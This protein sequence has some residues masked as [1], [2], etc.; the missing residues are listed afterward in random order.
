MSIVVNAAR[1]QSANS[2][3]KSSIFGWRVYVKGVS[4][5][6]KAYGLLPA[7]PM[8]WRT[9]TIV[10]RDGAWWLSVLV[11]MQPRRKAVGM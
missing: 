2:I 8:S 7:E 3:R 10:W 9:G 6:I 1:C 4:G 5:E 11:E